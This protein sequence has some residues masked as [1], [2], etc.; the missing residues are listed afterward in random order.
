MAAEFHNILLPPQTLESLD[1]WGSL[2]SLPLSLDSPAWEA[3]GIYRLTIG[4]SAK[5]GGSLRC[6]KVTT[7]KLATGTAKVQE[8]FSAKRTRKGGGSSAAKSGKSFKAS[9]SRKG[10]GSFAATTMQAFSSVRVR[11]VTCKTGAKSGGVYEFFVARPAALAGTANSGESLKCVRIRTVAKSIKAVA[12]QRFKSG[13]D[14]F[15]TLADSL[16]GRA[17]IATCRVRN[18]TAIS[19]ALTNEALS[20]TRSRSG[21]ARST[22]QGGNAF[23]CKATFAGVGKLKAKTSEIVTSIR[24][25]MNLVGFMP[26]S[27][28]ELDNFGAL[29]DLPRSLDDAVWSKPALASGKLE[30]YSSSARRCEFSAASSEAARFVRVRNSL[31]SSAAETRD[32]L[33][34][35]KIRPEALLGSAYSSGALAAIRSWDNALKDGVLASERVSVNRVRLSTGAMSGQAS[36]LFKLD[37]TKAARVEGTC[38]ASGSLRGA[39]TRISAVEARVRTG[40]DFTSI[41]VRMNLV[42]F[43]PVSL[44]ELDGFGALDDLPRSLD[45]AVWSKPILARGKLSGWVTSTR[46][47]EFFAA[48]QDETQVVR[49]RTGDLHNDGEVAISAEIFSSVRVRSLTGSLAGRTSERLLSDID[50]AAKIEAVA[51]SG[52]SLS[53]A[54]TRLV[55]IEASAQSGEELTANRIRMSLVGFKMTSLEEL[56]RFGAL[57]DLPQSLDDEVWGKPILA[58][59]LVTGCVTTSRACEFSADSQAVMHNLRVRTGD[60]HGEDETA[61]SSE[62]FSFTRIRTESATFVATISES[63]QW[64]RTRQ[65]VLASSSQAMGRLSLAN[66]LYFVQS[67]PGKSGE[68][69]TA[70][71]VRAHRV[72]SSV[73]SGQSIATLRVRQNVT[74]GTAK[75]AENVTPLRARN[76]VLAEKA[77]SSGALLASLSKYEDIHG[78]AYSSVSFEGQ[79]IRTASV[80]ATATTGGAVNGVNIAKL[81]LLGTATSAGSFIAKRDVRLAASASALS[82]SAFVGHV[83]GHEWDT[84]RRPLEA[85]W[86]EKNTGSSSWVQMSEDEAKWIAQDIPAQ[87]WI[88]KHGG[89]ATW[90]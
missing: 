84:E 49:V 8:K 68:I 63:S 37:V 1:A 36:G 4:D 43:M 13:R 12:S 86:N 61:I 31:L 88:Q 55:E 26:V 15:V 2:D 17:S 30:G 5:S 81:A 40:E 59:G 70:S 65:D 74:S 18:I 82:N 76:S 29:D 73:T 44:E 90:Q 60:L 6:V 45:D 51:T 10:G 85:D 53:S 52:D 32:Y 67:E 79:R 39:M 23:S 54:R 28:E 48:S 34:A 19:S 24:V 42:G 57:D 58:N 64:L 87:G 80:S 35:I 71:R 25:R 27:L 41:R 72:F 56:D 16:L 78:N 9:R 47:G 75:S 83:L 22:A 33:R 3:A 89:V 46:R 11:S 14:R 21:V 7:A 20:A 69:F 66:T 38:V 77:T 50:R 62:S